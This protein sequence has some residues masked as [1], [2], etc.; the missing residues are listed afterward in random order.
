MLCLY[1]LLKKICTFTSLTATAAPSN[2]DF[3][4]SSVGILDDT[5]FRE[6]PLPIT[7]VEALFVSPLARCFVVEKGAD[8]KRSQ[9][10]YIP[11]G[12]LNRVRV[13]TAATVR[14]TGKILVGKMDTLT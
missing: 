4:L 12:E 11:A 13:I 3:L 2:D 5:D 6:K 9:V 7:V 8:A 1:I 10:K 14:D